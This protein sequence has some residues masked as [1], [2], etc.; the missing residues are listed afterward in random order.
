M[1]LSGLYGYIA[2]GSFADL[3]NWLTSCIPYTMLIVFI[4]NCLFN[5]VSAFIDL[6]GK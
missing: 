1:S 3:V 6:G 5:V 4:L 2:F